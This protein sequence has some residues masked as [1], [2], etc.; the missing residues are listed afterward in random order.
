MKMALKCFL[1][2]I[3]IV[4]IFIFEINFYVKQS[5]KNRIIKNHAYLQ[6]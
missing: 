1:I 2:G 6:L 3:V 4:I 5:T